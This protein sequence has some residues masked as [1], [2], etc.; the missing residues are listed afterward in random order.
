MKN[1][2]TKKKTEQKYFVMG[3]ILFLFMYKCIDLE[4]IRRNVLAA[5]K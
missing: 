2:F 3:L 4:K 1:D 5:R